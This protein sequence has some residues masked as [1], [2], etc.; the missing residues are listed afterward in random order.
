MPSITLT[1]SPT[2][3]LYS[4]MASKTA[5]SIFPARICKLVTALDGF[6]FAVILARLLLTISR[7]LCSRL[8]YRIC[9]PAAAIW[10]AIW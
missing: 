3:S 8:K 5:S 9:S 10:S 1:R 7:R 6:I 2:V 4:S